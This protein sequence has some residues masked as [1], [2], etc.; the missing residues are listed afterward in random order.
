[1]SA[2]QDEINPST[3]RQAA[4]R[5]SAYPPHSS[6][7]GFSIRRKVRGKPPRPTTVLPRDRA[8]RWFPETV[9]AAA[10]RASYMAA[11]AMSAGLNRLPSLW[12]VLL[13]GYP[14]T[15]RCSGI[16]AERSSPPPSQLMLRAFGLTGATAGPAAGAISSRIGHI[17]SQ[18]CCCASSPDIRIRAA[19]HLKGS[20]GW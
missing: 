7:R 14:V 1:M 17:A 16:V 20:S 11:K 18:V 9:A 6:R 19:A 2:P 12:D 13:I 8:R 10:W 3:C 5:K 15:T 4:G